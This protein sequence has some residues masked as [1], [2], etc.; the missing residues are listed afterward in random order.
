M[1]LFQK[2]R[3]PDRRNENILMKIKNLNTA[4]YCV[5]VHEHGNCNVGTIVQ[6]RTR[7]AG[8]LYCKSQGKILNESKKCKLYFSQEERFLFPVY[9]MICLAGAVTLSS[10]QVRSLYSSFSVNNSDK[11]YHCLG[12]NVSF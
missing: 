4:F 10:I 11:Y 3:I 2:I 6:S 9:P 5:F 12:F 8:F 1:F 7:Y